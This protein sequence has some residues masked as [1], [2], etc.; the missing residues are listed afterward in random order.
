MRRI[1]NV[2]L[3]VPCVVGPYTS[4]NCILTLLRS[5]LRVKPIGEPYQRQDLDLRF[6]DYFGSVEAIVTSSGQNDSGMFETNLR[7]ERFCH[8]RAQVLRVPGS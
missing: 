1:K 8:L 4:I 3:S 2:A 6:I 5:T 7:D